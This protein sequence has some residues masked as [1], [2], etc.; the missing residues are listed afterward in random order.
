MQATQLAPTRRFLDSKNLEQIMST[1]TSAHSN[2]V[3]WAKFKELAC[4]GRK[5]ALD[6]NTRTGEVVA[7]Y[8]KSIAGA[9]GVG[10]LPQTYTDE[11]ERVM[12]HENVNF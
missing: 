2:Y 12:T 4:A 8:T 10:S 9:E 7:R 5:V 1:N 3:A 6:I 11:W